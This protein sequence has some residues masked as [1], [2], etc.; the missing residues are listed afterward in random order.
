MSDLI[1][2]Q[3][4]ISALLEKGQRSKRYKLGEIWELNF[5]EIREALTS[6]LSAGN[7]EE[8]DKLRDQLNNRND[9]I[10]ELEAKCRD[11]AEELRKANLAVEHNRHLA[12]EEQLRG[13]L[14]YRD[15][16]IYGLKYATRCNGVS[17]GEVN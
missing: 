7:E 5:D 9:Y 4:A 16:V 17:G 15:G 14:R 1:S 12:D 6:V 10:S 13:E 2:R 11:L 8:F 3:D